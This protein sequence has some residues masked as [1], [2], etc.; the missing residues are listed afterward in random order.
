MRDISP[1]AVIFLEVVMKRIKGA[2]IWD[3][4]IASVALGVAVAVVSLVLCSAVCALVISFFNIPT[5][6]VDLA[7]MIALLLSGALS[8]SVTARVA[9]D[10]GRRRA[11]I[12]AAVTALMIIAAALIGTGGKIGGR[13]FMNLACY[14]M[15]SV[16]FALIKFKGSRRRR[17]R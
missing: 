15:I 16:L 17:R 8:A 12:C 14:I 10:G 2:R 7:A 11:I 9:K 13:I 6:Q 3:G 4:K 5:R 1:L